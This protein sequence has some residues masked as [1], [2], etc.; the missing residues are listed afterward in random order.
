MIGCLDLV[1]FFSLLLLWGFDL[2]HFLVLFS[3][4]CPILVL[5]S[6]EDEIHIKSPPQSTSSISSQL[7]LISMPNISSHI[8]RSVSFPLP[9]FPSPSQLNNKNTDPGAS[10]FL[11]G[12]S[13]YS[14]IRIGA[15][16]RVSQILLYGV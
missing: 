8:I 9:P 2:H 4:S 3:F 1:G 12:S 14:H 11:P 10:L 16:I 7:H 6:R 15:I 5:F 13:H